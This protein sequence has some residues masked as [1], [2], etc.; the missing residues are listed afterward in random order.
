MCDRVLV[1]ARGRV[2]REL[3]GPEVTKERITEQCLRSVEA[4]E[5]LESR[6]AVGPT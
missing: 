2:V 1:F 6:K 5:G 3:R 4:V